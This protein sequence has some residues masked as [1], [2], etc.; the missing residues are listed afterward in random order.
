MSK[1]SAR[2]RNRLLPKRLGGRSL[3]RSLVLTKMDGRFR[4][5][6]R[7]IFHLNISPAVGLF[8]KLILDWFVELPRR[9]ADATPG[10]EI[11]RD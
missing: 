2:S 1:I 11:G 6:G 4:H 8:L 3:R 5:L 10:H 9:C 7:W